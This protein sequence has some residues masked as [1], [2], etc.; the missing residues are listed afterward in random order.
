MAQVGGE[1]TVGLVP[2][3]DL[4]PEIGRGGFGVVHRGV[5]V[6]VGR[7]VAVKIDSRPFED[8]RNRRRFL[9]EATAAS[10]ISGHPHVVSLIDVGVTR[11]GR[12][13][14]VMELCPHGSLAD[15]LR[16]QGPLTAAEARDLGLAVCG[17]LAAAHEAGIVH[18]DVKPANVLIDGFGTPRLSDFGLAA[19][20]EPGRDL[21]VTLEAL[22]PAYASPEAFES[23]PPTPRSD[24]WSMGAT[25]HAM[26]SRV[27]PR[28]TADG[29]P[30]P[31]PELIARLA[32]PMPDP[33]IPGSADLMRVIARACAYNPADRY[34][35]AREMYDDLK[36]LQ[37]PHGTGG[38]VLGGP[39]A[40]FTSLPAPRPV[41]RAGG[42]R[43]PGLVAA[44]ALGLTVGAGVTLGIADIGTEEPTAARAGE[45]PTTPS[46]SSSE[47]AE[48][49]EEQSPSVG[50][51]WGGITN[52]TGQI[53][54][55]S[56]NCDTAH[57]WET[58]A[59]GLLAADIATPYEE[60]VLAD[61]TVAATC[62]KEA[63]Q[64]YLGDDPR[65]RN[66]TFR[67]EVIP[68]DQ[69]AF[70]R[71]ARGFSCVA[72]LHGEGARTTSLKE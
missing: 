27:S 39:E 6:S 3:V 67:T 26:I 44:C 59:S 42:R 70:T 69:I 31:I 63:L 8:E 23:R 40:A 29:S 43:W 58:Y 54:A 18:R 48:T 12:P 55:R 25:L 13:Y 53:T 4:G 1:A 56:A 17:A 24:V 16:A 65:Y 7:E 46:G 64:A 14:L 72:S 10:R 36:A 34:P 51:C 9:R 47:Q 21:S 61:P 30:T 35:T 68:P 57:N 2:G 37:L 28:R 52:I 5:Q 19:M 20:P 66:A 32:E 50:T 11:D 41:R 22:T 49:A 33:G 60:D 15:V 38:R 45:P 71:G 62:G